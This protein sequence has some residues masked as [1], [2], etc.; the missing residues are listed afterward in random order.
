MRWC[1]WGLVPVA[2]DRRPDL[3]R[4]AVGRLGGEDEFVLHFGH[5]TEAEYGY[6]RSKAG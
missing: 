2:L 1:L 5:I 3:W 4:S 6:A